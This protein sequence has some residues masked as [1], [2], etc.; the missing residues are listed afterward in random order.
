MLVRLNLIAFSLCLLALPEGLAQTAGERLFMRVHLEGTHPD[1]TPAHI[2]AVF[3]PNIHTPSH[4]IGLPGTGHEAQP[5]PA[6]FGA[7]IPWTPFTPGDVIHAGRA[8]GWV[9]VTAIM[10]AYHQARPEGAR[11]GG[12]HRSGLSWFLTLVFHSNELPGNAAYGNLNGV[13][14]RLDLASSPKDETIIQSVSFNTSLSVVALHMPDTSTWLSPAFVPLTATDREA[15]IFR[16]VRPIDRMHTFAEA[17]VNRLAVL[18]AEGWSEAQVPARIRTLAWFRDGWHYPL[19][20]ETA[21]AKEEDIARRMGIAVMNPKLGPHRRPGAPWLDRPAH[22]YEEYGSPNVIDARWLCPRAPQRLA[23]LYAPSVQRRFENLTKYTGLQRDEPILVKL[24]DEPFLP[25]IQDFNQSPEARERFQSYLAERG[26]EETLDDQ[27]LLDLRDVQDERTARLYYY[28]TWFRV[29]TTSRWWKE[30][31]GV[32]RDIFGSGARMG[33]CC[34]FNGIYARP[35]WLWM[36]YEGAWDVHL[37]HYVF[38]LSYPIYSGKALAGL[39]ETTRRLYGVEGGGL[40]AP[41]RGG[42]TPAGDERVL[43]SALMRGFTTFYHYSYGPDAMPVPDRDRMRHDLALG[44]FL[45]RLPA[46]EDD[47][48]D[49]E[50]S[51]PRIAIFHSP[52]SEMWERAPNASRYGS[53]GM[54]SRGRFTEKEMIY[55]ALAYDQFDADFLPEWETG[56]LDQYAVLYVVDPHVPQA[57]REPLRA[58]VAQGGTLCLFAEAA[59]LNEYN[60]PADFLADDLGLPI[61]VRSMAYRNSLPWDL[62]PTGELMKL[63]ALGQMRWHAHE[64]EALATFDVLARREVLDLADATVLGRYEDG[65]VAALEI[66]YGKGRI[67]RMGTAVGLTYA[68]DAQPT[69]ERGHLDVAAARVFPEAIA[70]VLRY[71]VHSAGL[72][73]PLHITQ[74]HVDAR[75]FQNGS[76]TLLVLVDY[77]TDEERMLDIKLPGVTTHTKAKLLDGTE[78]ELQQAN[79]HTHLRVPV[80]ISE[81][82]VLTD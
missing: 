53:T 27:P 50:T 63:P 20:D 67:I 57:A 75:M 29:K 47:L 3:G 44:R 30:Y 9:D 34:G 58:W 18:E 68:R 25:S 11:H 38:G 22:L 51:A 45:R 37:H 65:T 15:F 60:E 24:F 80:S 79:G 2:A 55:T 36:S 62:Y 77:A 1:G 73:R 41:G 7:H 39:Q 12:A 54:K 76:R 21:Y 74:D 14:G 70:D 10:K 78:L 71:P 61:S 46:I 16:H 59:Q 5:F 64:Q 19:F 35:D 40:L 66:P 49:G 26:F 81:Y 52:S 33:T 23:D 32:Y 56:R 13:N 42:T 28:S 69:F 31:A 82:I 6:R 8:T 43:T 48:L 17:A 72:T 4:V